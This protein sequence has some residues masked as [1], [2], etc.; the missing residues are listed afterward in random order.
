M[1]SREWRYFW[2]KLGLLAVAFVFLA[3][4]FFLQIIQHDYYMREATAMRVKQYE[5]LAKRGQVYFMDGEENVVPAIMNERTWTVFVDPYYIIKNAGTSGV[6]TKEEVQ[7]KLTEV[8]GDKIIVKWDKVWANEENMYVEIAKQ[9]EYDTVVKIKEMNLKGVGRKETS[10]RV[11]PAGKLAS[12]LLGFINAE[13]VGSGVE[14]SL[15]KRLTGKDGMLKTVTDVNEIPITVGDD[16]IEIP[17]EDGENIVLTVDEN[18]QRKV[19]KVLEKTVTSKKGKIATASA[20]VMDPRNG[21]IMAMANYPNYDPGKYWVEEDPNIY[22]NRV[23]ETPYEPASVC[24]PFTYAAALNE[25]KLNPDATYNNTGKTT[26]GD[27]VINNAYGTATRNG[28]ITFRKALDYSLNTGSIEVLRKLGDGTNITKQARTTLYN[29]LTDNFGLGHKTGIEI[30]EASGTIISPENEEGNAVRYANMTFG[31]G[32]NLTM[33]Q[34]AAGFS[35]LI[36]GGLYYQP[37]IIAGT[38][39]DGK[40][41]ANQQQPAVRRAV[42]EATSKEMRKLLE[43]VRS[44]NGGDKDIKGYR[45][46]VK[47]GTAETLDKNG[48]YT[49]AKTVAGALGYGGAK[50]DGAMPEYVV[51]IRLDG[52]TLLWG[53]L[54][55]IPVFTEISNY[56]LQYLRIEPTK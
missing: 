5:L 19:E 13:G 28:V 16:N 3:R 38:Y 15:N 31:Q 37:T 2:L 20:M 39:E 50:R 49:S 44:V 26:V 47:T 36:N 54:D 42:S 30:H 6:L 35:S 11:Y 9:V 41:V 4:L 56:M 33:L 48:R 22:V 40:L 34:V 45:V 27:R 21:R 14:G 25:G 46:G 24:K 51:M 29:Y 10:R 12:Q 52:N 7:A 43:E 17:A 8:L 55:A 18:I 1:T 32:M 53:S 23:A